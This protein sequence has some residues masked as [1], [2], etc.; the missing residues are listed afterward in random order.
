M[1]LEKKSLHLIQ[2]WIEIALTDGAIALIDKDKDWTSF[3]VVAKLRN[4]FRIRKIGHTGT[5]DP[6]A[7][8]LL[9]LCFGKL[10]KTI[11]RDRKSVV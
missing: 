4:V 3:D 7:T 6:L 1:I 10:T 5:L 9:I 2:N 8:G 11:D